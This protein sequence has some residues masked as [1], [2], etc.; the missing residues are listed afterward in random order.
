[1]SDMEPTDTIALT[2]PLAAVH[3]KPLGKIP[4]AQAARVMRRI[5]DGER[6]S[7]LDVA[8]FNSAP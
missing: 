2:E 8:A 4:E 7:R 5:V 6:A 3:E 1:M